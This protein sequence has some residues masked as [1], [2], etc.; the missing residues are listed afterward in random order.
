MYAVALVLVS[1][2]ILKFNWY[3]K[4][5]DYPADLLEGDVV[6]GGTDRAIPAAAAVAAT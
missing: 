5:H 2:V 4:L 3:D 1:M 6:P